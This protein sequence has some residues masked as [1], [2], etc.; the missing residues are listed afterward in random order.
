MKS[1]MQLFILFLSLVSTATIANADEI[2][3]GKQ[4]FQTHCASC[5]GVA[6][7]MDMSK[8]KAP[9]IIAVRKHYIGTY[10]D[11]FSFVNT[12]ADWVENPDKNK[13]QMRG[14]IRR[15]GLM[16]KTT[17]NRNDVEKIAAYIFEGEI[18]TP[19]GFQEH[20]KRMHGNR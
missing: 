6:G 7:G 20:V 16:P 17:V 14:A 12:I 19:A 10:S 13:T 18:D 3:K 11:K 15:F 4:L 2:K 9:P 1:S 5:H 8:R